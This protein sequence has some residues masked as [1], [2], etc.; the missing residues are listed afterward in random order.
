MNPM[1]ISIFTSVTVSVCKQ[2]TNLWIYTYIFIN[3][4][5]CIYIYIYAYMLLKPCLRSRDPR[6]APGSDF[7]EP[8]ASGL[9]SCRASGSEDVRQQNILQ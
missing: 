9:P 3:T 6:F 5:M 2:V 4:S 1:S 7:L 8:N